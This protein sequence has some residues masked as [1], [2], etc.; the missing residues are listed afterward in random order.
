MSQEYKRNFWAEVKEAYPISRYL[1]DKQ[2]PYKLKG[3]V[4]KLS[5]PSPF[6]SDSSPS[7]IVYGDRQFYCFGCAG[8]PAAK[9]TY[10]GDI[11]DLASLIEGRP[12]AEVL[13]QLAEAAGIELDAEQHELL[14]QRFEETDKKRQLIN[15]QSQALANDS[16]WLTYLMKTRGLDLNTISF[17]ELGYSPA[18]KKVSIPLRDDLARPLGFTYHH[19]KSDAKYKNPETSEFFKKDKFLYN[20]ESL[21]HIDQKGNK[22]Y[23]VEGYFDVMSMWQAGYRTVVGLCGSRLTNGHIELLRKYINRETRI[24][25]VPDADEVGWKSLESNF[26]LLRSKISNPCSVAIMDAEGVK[27]ANDW[28]GKEKKE[29]LPR[30]MP[31]Y[32]VI[33]QY[34]LSQCP[35]D[36]EIQA[37]RISK[38]LKRAS[39]FEKARSLKTL[40]EV[41]GL[42]EEKISRFL[43]IKTMD[44]EEIIFKDTEFRVNEYSEYVKNLDSSRM[45]TGFIEID[46]AIRGI[47][48]GEIV[49]I[50]GRAN[51]CK[52][53]M[54]TDLFNKQTKLSKDV[55]TIFFSLE[56]SSVQLQ[57]RMLTQFL[58]VVGDEANPPAK[59]VEDLVKANDP[60]VMAALEQIKTVHQNLVIVDRPGLTVKD[61]ERFIDLAEETVFGKP[62]GLVIV[63]HLHII[64]NLAKTDYERISSNIKDFRVMVKSRTACAGVI[65][66]QTSRK[67]GSGGD[68]ITM[69]DARGSGEI[70]ETVDFMIGVWRPELKAIAEIEKIRTEAI[71]GQPKL[72]KDENGRIEKREDGARAYETSAEAYARERRERQKRLLIAQKAAEDQRGVIMMQI[73]KSRREG[74]NA[75]FMYKMKGLTL[76]FLRYGG[77]DMAVNKD[78]N[79]LDP[80]EG[81]EPKPPTRT[82]KPKQITPSI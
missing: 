44:N 10:Q 56:M 11:F 15:L 18:Q 21:V 40:A 78:E 81:Q 51:S 67:G 80:L 50:M 38:A 25:F 41:W 4:L 37:M 42:S 8:T 45:S 7:F 26:E 66:I 62:V 75:I 12:K 77:A 22:L 72:K 79:L 34:H 57:E 69:D 20:V 68:S 71:G 55:P 33:V 61:M 58:G 82:P 24:V 76:E 5:C 52:T 74:R 32:D 36:P 28:F 1:E 29:A 64:K 46:E 49:G 54:A 73:L 3:N 13:A 43:N 47:N 35:E 60:T 65:L 9:N 23:V 19:P 2:I 70:E 27:D 14:K 6:H 63:D 30:E 39:E 53:L 48:P 16:A 31:Y 59:I 17:F